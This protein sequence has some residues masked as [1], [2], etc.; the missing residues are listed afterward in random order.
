M[1]DLLLSMLIP[2]SA[3]E[4]GDKSSGLLASQALDPSLDVEISFK[5]VLAAAQRIVSSVTQPDKKEN[6]ALPLAA[7]SAEDLQAAQLKFLSD[8]QRG[9]IDDSATA[10]VNPLL[11]P[12]ASLP[13]YHIVAAVVDALPAL[14]P[15]PAA[16]LP[17]SSLPLE[18][19][20]SDVSA[21]DIASASETPDL[22][23]IDDGAALGDSDYSITSI[24]SASITSDSIASASI[25]SAALSAITPESAPTAASIVPPATELS[26]SVVASLVPLIGEAD[27]AT[28]ASNISVTEIAEIVSAPEGEAS[29]VSM[30][31]EDIVPLKELQKADENKYEVQEAVATDSAADSDSASATAT[32]EN[33]VDNLDKTKPSPLSV[34]AAGAQKASENAV[35]VAKNIL[36]ADRSHHSDELSKL[37]S[38][39]DTGSASAAA[40]LSHSRLVDPGLSHD[41]QVLQLQV[42][43]RSQHPI[44]DQLRVNIQQAV[45]DGHDQISLRLSPEH[46]GRIDISINVDKNGAAQ[47]LVVA[48]RQETYDMM[49]RD[50][51]GLERALSDAG[52]KTDNGSLEFQ[53]RGQNQQNA[54]AQAGGDGRRGQGQKNA[55]SNGTLRNETLTNDITTYR[56]VATS[57]LNIQV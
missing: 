38:N 46:L 30:Q 34:K 11:I 5:D 39:V 8:L 13:Q 27:V 1:S 42:Q 16:A 49:Q 12:Q 35:E 51:R 52:I 4:T 53:L 50:A 20:A 29:L 18:A 7:L 57:G 33:S 3:A 10:I 56:L 48:D 36:P 21:P 32:A 6:T 17:L 14:Q 28:S 54:F 19:F 37:A 31:S 23:S 2:S 47:V 43:V 41:S 44:G 26:D 25:N 40:P 55:F 15:A 45:K 22:F 24:A 9:K